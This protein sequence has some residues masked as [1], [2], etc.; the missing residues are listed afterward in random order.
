[1][2][3]SVLLTA[4][5]VSADAFFVG[6]SLHLR[7]A[8]ILSAL[9]IGYAFAAYGISFLIHERIDAE[10]LRWFVAAAFLCMGIRNFFGGGD[11]TNILLLSMVMSVDVIVAVLSL[12][13]E[14]DCPMFVPVAVGASHLLAIFI[15]VALGETCGINRFRSIVSGVCLILVAILKIIV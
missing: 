5:L 14:Y 13:V 2:T 15:G 6:V 1:M 12:S 11:K 10:I 7:R 9:L 8:W 4:L 3:L